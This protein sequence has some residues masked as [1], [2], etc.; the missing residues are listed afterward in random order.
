[1]NQAEWRWRMWQVSVKMSFSGK[2][3]RISQEMWHNCPR[4][5]KMNQ[6]PFALR[7]KGKYFI[8]KCGESKIIWGFTFIHSYL[9]YFLQSEKKKL[10][11]LKVRVYL[12]KLWPCFVY[13]WAYLVSISHFLVKKN[14]NVFVDESYFTIWA[15][16]SL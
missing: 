5:E 15:N 14:R 1:M 2:C 6:W 7:T 4:W 9:E 16:V 3:I 10:W 12:N 13:A 8:M 11:K